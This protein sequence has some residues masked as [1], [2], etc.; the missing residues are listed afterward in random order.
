[1][2][3]YLVLVSLLI[4]SACSTTA[5]TTE[6][7]VED[8]VIYEIDTSSLDV[9]YATYLNETNP[10][11]VITFENYDPISL[12]LFPE[13]APIT[14][15]HITSL[16]ERN[17]YDGI[18][19]HRIIEGFMIQGGDPTGTG[20]GGSGQQITGEF[21]SNGVPNLLRHWRGVLSM[22]RSSEPNSASSQFFIVHRDAN[23]LDGEYAAFGGVVQGFETLD[24][25]ASVA[26]NAQDRPLD[27]VVMQTVRLI[28]G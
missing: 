22:A 13:V 25:L 19:F 24:A 28:G 23:F 18:I 11:I 4:L 10:R 21:V 16:V 5:E 1:M 7:V 27:A 12:E 15:A 9:P 2:R 6:P 3:K 14:V 8:V 26:T 17:F 20:G